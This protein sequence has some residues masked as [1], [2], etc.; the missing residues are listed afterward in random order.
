M[1]NMDSL[2]EQVEEGFIPD[3]GTSL[4]AILEGFPA[5]FTALSE[6][7]GEARRV[8]PRE[9]PVRG[10]RGARGRHGRARRVRPAG[11]R[12]RRGDQAGPVPEGR[13]TAR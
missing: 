11:G 10:G 8:D 1:V 13:V 9:R 5:F 2:I 4:A 7:L 6:R 12:V 3:S